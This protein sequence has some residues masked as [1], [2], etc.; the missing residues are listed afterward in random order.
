MM[1]RMIKDPFARL[2]LDREVLTV[3][4]LNGRARVLLE[5]VFSNIWVEGEISNLA[6][7]A[8][9][10]VY[11]TLKDSG[12]QVRCALFRNNAARV[13]Q[14][15]K[16]G[17][18]ARGLAPAS[19]AALQQRDQ[20]VQLIL[21]TRLRLEKLYA[22]PL[23]ADAMRAAKAA[24]FERLRSDYRQM[25]DSQWAGDKRYDAWIN[26]PMNNARLLPFGL[27]DQWVPAFAALFRQEG[28]DWLKFYAAVEKMGGLP[29]E[30]RKAAL[31]QLEN[32]AL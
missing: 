19:N 16:D 13:R 27:Y 14:A 1:A 2:N 23:A 12:A 30:Q 25:R 18:A 31:R 5:D 17:R 4:Q 22:Q 10:H 9:G 24:E 7:P 11:F 15:L 20:F 8:S 32:G 3:S 26:Q 29:L 6:R 28:G 21:D